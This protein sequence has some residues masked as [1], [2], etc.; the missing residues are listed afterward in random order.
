M[1]TPNSVPNGLLSN[2]NRLVVKAPPAPDKA[3]NV[4]KSAPIA[5]SAH[6]SKHAVLI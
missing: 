5:S 3:A 1:G 2:P 6:T 4:A